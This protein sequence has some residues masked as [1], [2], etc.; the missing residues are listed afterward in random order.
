MP[1]QDEIPISF[2]RFLNRRQAAAYLG[3]STSTFDI[4]VK[5]GMWPQASRRGGK[6]TALTWDKRI[7]DRAADRHAGLIESDAAGIDLKHSEMTVL[8]RIKHGVTQKPNGHQHR[9]QAVS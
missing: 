4:E 1:D 2:L 7:L 6:G 3:V 5:S 8:E 9:K